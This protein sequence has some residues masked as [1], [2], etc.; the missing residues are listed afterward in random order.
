MK[1]RYNYLSH[2]LD[3]SQQ[4][5]AR[6]GKISAFWASMSSAVVF[7]NLVQYLGAGEINVIAL[8]I[9][10]FLFWTSVYCVLMF[11]QL[12]WISYIVYNAVD[13]WQYQEEDNTPPTPPNNTRKTYYLPTKNGYKID[14]VVEFTGG[15]GGVDENEEE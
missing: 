3:S 4:A 14:K 13:E 1:R 15:V 5:V 8:M 2:M 9:M 6:I 11:S 10:Q 12:S 7:I